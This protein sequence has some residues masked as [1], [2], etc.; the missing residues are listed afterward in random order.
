MDSEHL[1]LGDITPLDQSFEDLAATT[2]RGLIGL[3]EENPTGSQPAAKR[4]RRD[5]KPSKPHF[6]THTPSNQFHSSILS[7]PLSNSHLF[8][9]PLFNPKTSAPVHTSRFRGVSLH[10][11]TNRWK[12]Q[13][14]VGRRDIILG[15]YT[16]QE[17]AAR[18]FDRAAICVR[19]TT[20]SSKLNFPFENYTNEYQ[21]LRSTPF[22][23]LVKELR[24]GAPAAKANASSMYTGVRKHTKSNNKW[25][26][27]L[28]L[29][30]KHV[31]LGLYE[32]ELAAAQAHDQA[33]ILRHAYSVSSNT[34]P[35][36]PAAAAA[37]DGEQGGGDG[38]N[39]SNN[40]KSVV[41][42]L[43]VNFPL[44]MYNRICQSWANGG[45]AVAIPP[46]EGEGGGE[47]GGQQQQEQNIEGGITAVDNNN[48]NKSQGGTAAAAAAA[49]TGNEVATTNDNN[50]NDN[51][52]EMNLPSWTQRLGVQQTG[53]GDGD[54][55]DNDE[56]QSNAMV[57]YADVSV[58]FP[59]Q[60]PV[61]FHPL[62][63]KY[64][65]AVVLRC[66]EMMLAGET[67]TAAAAIARGEA[68]VPLVAVDGVNNNANGVQKHGIIGID[69]GHGNITSN[70]SMAA[71]AS[72]QYVLYQD[73]MW[74]QL[75]EL[76]QEGMMMV[77]MPNGEVAHVQIDQ[78]QLLLH[79]Q[80][81]Q[82]QLEFQLQGGGGIQYAGDYLFHQPPQQQQQQQGNVP[83]SSNPQQQQQQVMFP[84]D[85]FS[86][87]PLDQTSLQA[88]FGPNWAQ[89]MAVLNQ[90]AAV[91]AAE[92]ENKSAGGGGGKEGGGDGVVEG[93]PP[94]NL[95]AIFESAQS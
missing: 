11:A 59:D 29:G 74:Q 23:D 36:L 89:M 32:S 44:T 41:Q 9:P 30:G 71:F 57:Q 37:A 94:Q 61:L 3:R 90:H 35:P 33:A 16:H 17:D 60:N 1:Q 15:R 80:Q 64:V 46:Q 19:G 24:K 28:R 51:E 54:K 72:G 21:R 69:G 25:E 82:Q 22:E 84:M 10:Q 20:D 87:S 31:H 95:A 93:S 43:K 70:N 27:Y 48:N 34:A 4:S 7:Y 91:A 67:T 45:S 42:E 50:D 6:S 53:N 75:A 63:E 66:Q 12:C 18:S 2:N 79:H 62:K 26:S 65:N 14:K 38:S 55:E 40:K 88:L 13:I 68:G 49:D 85:G 56:D 78:Q 83:E 92:G 58:L 76:Q 47:G 81:Q 5:D 52:N 73:V 8:S 39:N 86:T 77:I